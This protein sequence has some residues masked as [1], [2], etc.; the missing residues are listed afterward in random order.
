MKP[1]TVFLFTG[2]PAYGQFDEFFIG[3]GKA[4]SED[5]F[6]DIWTSADSLDTDMPI[7]D[8]SNIIELGTDT[9][10]LELAKSKHPEYFI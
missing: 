5:Y 4:T 1:G 6:D 10:W 8:Y 9:D 7:A 3:I 2:D